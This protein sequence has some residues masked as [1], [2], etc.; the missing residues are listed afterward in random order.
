MNGKSI[1]DFE[2]VK[3]WVEKDTVGAEFKVFCDV[4]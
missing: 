3:A 2:G 1:K 4:S